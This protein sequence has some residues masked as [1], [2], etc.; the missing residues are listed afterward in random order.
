MEGKSGS[1]DYWRFFRST[2][3]N[4]FEVIEKAIV[5][6][7]MNC[8]KEF[9][10]RR[11][12]IAEKLF[13]VRVSMCFGCNNVELLVPD[14]GKDLRDDEEGVSV[15]WELIEKGSNMDSC[16]GKVGRRL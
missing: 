9:R 16:N 6:T 2:E 12:G 10:S 15:K 5:V 3:V 14:T 4:I 11:G 13:S 8:Q 7:G 1:M